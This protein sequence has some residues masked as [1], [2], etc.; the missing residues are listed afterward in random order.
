MVPR[1]SAEAGSA[2]A[3]PLRLR[4]LEQRLHMPFE[5]RIATAG[6]FDDGGQESAA[7]NWRAPSAMACSR[8]C[9]WF[10]Q[11]ATIPVG[12]LRAR[13]SDRAFHGGWA[14]V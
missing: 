9:S 13:A 14:L 7:G 3:D 4:R 2:F 5:R 12:E 11:Y 1:A 10:H 6:S 8:G